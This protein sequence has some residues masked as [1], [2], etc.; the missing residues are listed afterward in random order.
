MSELTDY[1]DGKKYIDK[2]IEFRHSIDVWEQK[3]KPLARCTICV[4]KFG[5]VHKTD[6]LYLES[7]KYG[8]VLVCKN[9]R[10][11]YRG[12]K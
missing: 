1:K 6:N 10:R 7:R 2:I 12:K 8:D 3:K 5:D 4:L 11:N 9:H